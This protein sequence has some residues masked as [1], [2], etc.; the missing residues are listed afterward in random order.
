MTEVIIG[1]ADATVGATVE[2]AVAN[3]AVTTSRTG[4]IASRDGAHRRHRRRLDRDVVDVV[5]VEV[6]KVEVVNVTVEHAAVG[7][8]HPVSVLEPSTETTTATS[9]P[10][11]PTSVV[12]L[13]QGAGR[14]RR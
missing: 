8:R 6:M 4:S 2:V 14:S 5:T 13:R 11:P 12:T 9:A 10:A 3:K 1:A 7:G